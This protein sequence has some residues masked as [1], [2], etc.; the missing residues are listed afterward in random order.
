MNLAAGSPNIVRELAARWA[1]YAEVNE[2]VH[3]SEPV[4]YNKPV[5][6]GKF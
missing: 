6:P 1:V 3:P 4:F 2:V 5:S